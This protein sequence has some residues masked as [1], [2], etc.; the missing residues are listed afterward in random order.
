MP[1]AS[2]LLQHRLTRFILVG[3]SSAILLFL[4]NFLVQSYLDITPFY[5][6]AISYIVVFVL[7]YLTHRAWTFQ[8]NA[9]HHQTL[10]RYLATQF[11]CALLTSSLTTIFTKQFVPKLP[12][13]SA[14]FATLC[15]SALSFTASLLWVFSER[16]SKAQSAPTSQT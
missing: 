11:A 1:I 8:S 14:L 5:A 6:T 16:P 7:T 2:Y 15:A 13:V 3:G 9:A 4:L 12:F 10:P